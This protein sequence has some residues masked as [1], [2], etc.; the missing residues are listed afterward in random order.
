[1]PEYLKPQKRILGDASV[2][3]GNVQVQST[4]PTSAKKRKLETSLPQAN[5]QAPHLLSSQNGLKNSF[6]SASRSQPK[7]QFVEDVL[8]K[9]TQDIGD[10]KENNAEKDQK[11]ERPP[12]G[13]FDPSRDNLCF[14][15]I[16][17]QEGYLGGGTAV[18]LFGVTEVCLSLL[19]WC[20]LTDMGMA[21]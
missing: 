8:E 2:S 4:S 20:F 21:S 10:L 19:H 13:D 5:I 16:D 3:R 12:L 11:W 17:V 1:M 7:S 6:G 9:L 14:Q 18:K 15:Q